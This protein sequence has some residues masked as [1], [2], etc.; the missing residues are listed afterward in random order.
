MDLRVRLASLNDVREIV[1]VHCSDVEKW[2]RWTNGRRVEAEYEDL[3]IEERFMNGG[4]WMSVETCAI[5]LNNV[6]T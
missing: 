3:R 4:P 2:F 6:L 1:E 5:H